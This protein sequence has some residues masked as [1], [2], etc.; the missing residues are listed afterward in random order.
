MAD[1][2]LNRFKFAGMRRIL[3][4]DVDNTLVLWKDQKHPWDDGFEDEYRP[5]HAL[6]EAASEF[7]EK[8]SGRII[9][10]SGGGEVYA[11]LWRDRLFGNNRKELAA[12]SKQPGLIRPDDIVVDDM[13]ELTANPSARRQL[14]PRGIKVY[15]PDDLSWAWWKRGSTDATGHD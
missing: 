12:A 4:L 3:F 15:R 7:I 10:W 13:P 9:V 2:R 14:V 5:N 6:I 1:E 11:G 8:H